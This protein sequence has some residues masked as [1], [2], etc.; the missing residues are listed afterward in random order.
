M[1]TRGKRKKKKKRV[2][3]SPMYCTDGN[4]CS[5]ID[6][7]AC[8][9]PE[10]SDYVAHRPSQL[11]L[12]MAPSHGTSLSAHSPSALNMENMGS[13]LPAYQSNVIPFDQY[14]H[15]QPQFAMQHPG[16]Y[17]QMHPAPSFRSGGQ[18]TDDR[19]PAYSM[20]FPMV[21]PHYYPQPHQQPSYPGFP[22]YAHSPLP[23]PSV[24]GPMLGQI[25][26]YDS[27][28]YPSPYP[29]VLG[30]GPGPP[31]RP[32]MP[33]RSD[34]QHSNPRRPVSSGPGP[35]LHTERPRRPVPKRAAVSDYPKTIVDG[36]NLAKCTKSNSRVSGKYI[37]IHIMPSS[38]FFYA[39]L[40][41]SLFADMQFQRQSRLHHPQPLGLQRLEDHGGRQKNQALRYGLAIC[42]TALALWT[43]KS[44]FLRAF[45]TKSRAFSS[46]QE[47][48][49]HLSTMKQRLP[50]LQHRRDS[51]TPDFKAAVWFADYDPMRVRGSP[52]KVRVILQAS[53]L[54]R[55]RKMTR[56]LL[57]V[58]I[59]RYGPLMRRCPIGIS[60]LKV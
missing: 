44:T 51:T 7:T 16:L 3:I 9:E 15:M 39:L 42:L 52:G 41:S 33:P 45:R 23:H 47:V 1:S 60:L 34:A 40:N 53:P 19:H 35:T 46:S 27:A 38:F 13:T 30:H 11:N 4:I 48:I 36:S 12:Y 28:Y 10:R 22:T 55:V 29:M 5:C 26:G 14:H 6:T 58:L 43:S 8:H 2:P 32:Q 54:R 20:T 25:P 24:N 56:R 21:Y 17:Y 49:V 50:V 18:A 31:L 57:R 37:T 59:L